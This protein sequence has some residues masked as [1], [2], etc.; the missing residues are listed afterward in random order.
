MP[1]GG[2]FFSRVQMGGVFFCSVTK[3]IHTLLTQRAD[4]HTVPF[5]AAL[6]FSLVFPD[7]SI[8]FFF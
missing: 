7:Q 8:T 2:G 6:H 1:K 4:T 3:Q 5:S